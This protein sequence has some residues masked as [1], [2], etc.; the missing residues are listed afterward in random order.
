[1]S[2]MSFMSFMT[3][4]ADSS[5]SFMAPR[6]GRNRRDRHGAFHNSSEASGTFQNTWE[7]PSNFGTS[8]LTSTPL[9]SYE[10]FRNSPIYNYTRN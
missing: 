6:A 1:M 4:F 8:V 5:T 2:F 3:S 9:N 10:L 7:L